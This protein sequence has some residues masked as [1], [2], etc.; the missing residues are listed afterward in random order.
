MKAFLKKIT[1][2]RVVC[3]CV[4]VCVCDQNKHFPSCCLGRSYSI[5]SI[6]IAFASI[7]F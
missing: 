1:Y 2:T 6:Y 3:V 5:I 4:C 7:E